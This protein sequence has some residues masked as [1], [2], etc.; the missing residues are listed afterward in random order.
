MR[1]AA[2]GWW[3]TGVS[4]IGD[5]DPRAVEV[6]GGRWMWLRARD[7]V[8]LRDLGW[9]ATRAAAQARARQ[10]ERLLGEP[11]RWVVSRSD[12]AALN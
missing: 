10:M 8:L 12:R 6:E 11:R 1:W 2:R 4:N 5:W 3:W 9:F 7:G